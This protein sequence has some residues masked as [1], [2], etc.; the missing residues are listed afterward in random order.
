MAKLNDPNI[1]V[2]SIDANG[3][4][5]ITKDKDIA[6]ARITFNNGLVANLTASRLTSTPM[7]KFRLFQEAQYISL[8]LQNHKIELFNLVDKNTSQDIQSQFVNFGNKL[9][10]LHNPIIKPLNAMDEEQKAFFNAIYNDKTTACTLSEGAQAL[11]I[12]EKISDIIGN[13]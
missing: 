7:R 8:D 10:Q 2:K 6:N 11:E 9:I 3:V 4:S 1:E 12:A 5:I 13:L